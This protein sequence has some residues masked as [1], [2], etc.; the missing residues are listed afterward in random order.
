MK[1]RGVYIVGLPGSHRRQVAEY[2][3][4][5]LGWNILDLQKEVESQMHM[6]MLEIVDRDLLEEFRR[7]ERGIVEKVPAGTIIL[8]SDLL[9]SINE[10]QLLQENGIIPI[11]LSSTIETLE[12]NLVKDTQAHPILRVKSLEDYQREL[13]NLLPHMY[14][15]P[16]EGF[17]D[18][19]VAIMI[20]RILRSDYNL[21]YSNGEKIYLGINSFKQLSELLDLEGFQDAFFITY[22]RLFLIHFK[23]A[24]DVMGNFQIPYDVFYLPDRESVKNLDRAREL[25]KEFIKRKVSKF[26]PIVAL[27]GG[28]TMDLTGFSASTFQGGMYLVLI[29]TTFTAQVEAAIGGVNMLN[30]NGMRNVLGTSYYPRFI[31]L[32]PVFLLSLEEQEFRNSLSTAIKFGILH[33]EEILQMLESNPQDFNNMYLPS[34]EVLIRKTALAKLQFIQKDI[35]GWKERKFIKFGWIISSVLQD[36]MNI[37][38]SKALAIGMKMALFMSIRRGILRN[39]EVVDRIENLYRMYSIDA[40]M[41]PVPREKLEEELSYLDSFYRSRIRIVLIEDIGKPVIATTS[42]QELMEIFMDFMGGL[43]NTL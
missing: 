12:R 40:T 31:L 8:S 13:E 23:W 4:R 14:S 2:L 37:P 6:G 21:I 9:P 41:E 22:K 36:V 26:T 27:G 17:T 1:L 38:Y 18:R 39:M 15:I 16:T 25:W 35:H 34:L 5:W 42:A 30:L 3:S 24:L 10:L 28:G 20:T 29:P 43:G 19:E 11:F 32:D 7:V 33:D